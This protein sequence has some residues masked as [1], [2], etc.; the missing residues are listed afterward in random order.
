M[1]QLTKPQLH[2]WT[3]DEYDQMVA[4]GLFDGKNVELIEGEVID[5]SPMG[6]GHAT[7]VALTAYSL[8]DAFGESY[9]VRWQ[10]PFNASDISEPEPDVAVV[11]GTVR[12]YT[13]AHPSSAVLIVEV[14]DSTLAYDRKQKTSLYAKA[15]VTDYWII[16]LIDHQLEVY[17]NPVPDSEQL[18]GFGYASKTVLR[19]GDVVIPLHKKVKIAVEQ[20]LP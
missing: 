18:Y 2:L 8:I 19:A 14:S 5:M 11:V 17:R 12:D 13:H 3:R 9:Y 4:I 6:S 10:L 7:A 16:N 20:L 15:G 1:R